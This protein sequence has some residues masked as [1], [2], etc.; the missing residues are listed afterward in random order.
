VSGIEVAPGSPLVSEAS[1]AVGRVS[2]IT[3]SRTITQP[4]HSAARSVIAQPGNW[5]QITDELQALIGLWLGHH[6]PLLSWPA[7]CQEA[8]ATA[9]ARIVL[10]CGRSAAQE[11]L[12]V[13]SPGYWQ[14]SSRK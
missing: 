9:I 10:A 7:G 12:Q 13:T 11:H 14:V 4:G 3:R 8:A 2:V 6:A 5:D 1:F